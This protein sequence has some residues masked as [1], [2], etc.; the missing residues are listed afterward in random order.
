MLTLENA[1]LTALQ[2]LPALGKSARHVHV[3]FCSSR[4]VRLT[5]VLLDEMLL[6][7]AHRKAVWF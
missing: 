7:I 4:A 3:D 1:T 2:T 6:Y 5:S